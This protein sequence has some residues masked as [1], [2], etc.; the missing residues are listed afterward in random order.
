[1][2][3][4]GN[5]EDPSVTIG[6]GLSGL[7][8]QPGDY[9]VVSLKNGDDGTSA[10]TE[11]IYIL[12]GSGSTGQQ[13]IVDNMD[14]AYGRTRTI[15]VSYYNTTHLYVDVQT[16]H[17]GTEYDVYIL[18][19]DTTYNYLGFMFT[20]Y[21]EPS[22]GTWQIMELSFDSNIYDMLATPFVPG[23]ST[24]AWT[25][26]T[27]TN[28][29]FYHSTMFQTLTTAQQATMSHADSNEKYLIELETNAVYS[30]PIWC[31]ANLVGVSSIGTTYLI[32]PKLLYVPNGA[33]PTIGS[34][35][36]AGM[37]EDT[38]ISYIPSNA[39]FYT[40]DQYGTWWTYPVTTCTGLSAPPVAVSGIYVG[41]DTGGSGSSDLII[42]YK[43]I[44]AAN[45]TAYNIET[46]LNTAQDHTVIIETCNGTWTYPTCVNGTLTN[47]STTLNALAFTSSTELN[48]TIANIYYYIEDDYKCQY[49]QGHGSLLGLGSFSFIGTVLEPF[50]GTLF[51]GIIFILLFAVSVVNPFFVLLPIFFNDMFQ[52]VDTATLAVL[53][54]MCGFFSVFINHKVTYA[55]FKT[56]L[57][58]VVFG[59]C[60]LVYYYSLVPGMGASPTVTALDEIQAS[61]DVLTTGTPDFMD[62]V[63]GFNLITAIFGLLASIPILILQIIP[64]IFGL[65]SPELA[66]AFARFSSII[67]IGIMAFLIFKTYEII[68]GAMTNV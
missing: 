54:I 66:D 22:S 24:A 9:T 52:I 36:A 39:S 29:M 62:M 67:T 11:D 59:C 57:A 15:N 37:Y 68:K 31:R 58:Y 17:E 21:K 26:A 27:A 43:Q 25:T 56:V 44:C 50:I 5:G 51:S 60:V 30:A 10:H 35:A 55:S 6:L 4:T 33:G 65:L 45:A 20:G 12:T 64:A 7:D 16:D 46:K 42:P 53:V 14:W 63:A 41:A 32:E 48:D 34:W 40:L 2:Y 49:V 38:G 3:S 8:W 47:H 1:L 13:K 18:H 23:P 28:T 61:T 19:D